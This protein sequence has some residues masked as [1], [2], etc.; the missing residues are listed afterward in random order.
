MVKYSSH[1]P[2]TPSYPST[3]LPHPHLSLSSPSFPHCFSCKPKS[4]GIGTQVGMVV[5]RQALKHN[6]PKTKPSCS[7]SKVVF[8]M[9]LLEPNPQT[10]RKYQ[11]PNANLKIVYLHLHMQ[12][13]DPPCIELKR[14]FF[15]PGDRQSE[16]SPA[17][18]E[19]ICW[20]SQQ[21]ECSMIR[22]L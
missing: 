2:S 10:Y 18:H 5:E 22:T 15:H 13:W 9:K 17:D 21:S 20:I 14:S 19:P 8:A 12:V 4:K 11:S 1:A 6:E 7:K 16:R 3:S